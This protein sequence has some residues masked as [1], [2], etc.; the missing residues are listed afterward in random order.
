MVLKIAISKDLLV[1]SPTIKQVFYA[2][3][4]ITFQRE[5]EFI[6]VSLYGTLHF[7]ARHSLEQVLLCPIS[8]V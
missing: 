2:K 5:H 1:L 8:H 4:S 3:N 7:L 6:A